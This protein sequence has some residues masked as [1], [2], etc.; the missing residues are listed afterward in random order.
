MTRKFTPREAIRAAAKLGWE[1]RPKK[2][3]GAYTFRAPSGETFTCAA[4]GRADRVPLKL[5]QALEKAM[6]A[7]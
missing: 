3:T 2:A 4:P 1:V 6:E 5:A 7:E